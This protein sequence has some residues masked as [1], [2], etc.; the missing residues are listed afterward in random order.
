MMALTNALPD[1]EVTRRG[2]GS[3][4]AVEVNVARICLS[5]TLSADERRRVD[6]SVRVHT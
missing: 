3:A 5:R 4:T 2:D 1:G 6:V